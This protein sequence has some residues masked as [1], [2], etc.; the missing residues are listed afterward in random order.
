MKKLKIRYI[1]LFVGT[2][3]LSPP[4]YSFF[5]TSDPGEISGTIKT[6]LVEL[7]SA[8][9]T[10]QSTLNQAK[11]LTAIGDKIGAIKKFVD[12]EALKAKAEE[13]KQLAEENKERLEKLRKKVEEEKSEKETE[14]TEKE[15]EDVATFENFGVDDSLTDE[16]G[17]SSVNIKLPNKEERTFLT[18][19]QNDIPGVSVEKSENLPVV[20]KPSM[21]KLQLPAAKSRGYEKRSSSDE[22]YVVEINVSYAQ[23][24]GVKTGTNN[25]GRFL[26]SDIIATK[27]NM[28]YDEVTKENVD[29]CINTWVQCLDGGSDE[30]SGIEGAL[31]CQGLY[32]KAVHEQV[33]ADLTSALDNKEYANSF[34]ATVA[35]DLENKADTPSSEREDMAYIGLVNKVNQEIL[36]KMLHDESAQL[37]QEALKSIEFVDAAYYKQGD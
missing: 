1:V 33:A 26:Y 27:C 29:K 11:Q 24:S 20:V 5:L 28:N 23:I 25:E 31:S 34:E 4:C 9:N 32:K 37:I 17:D 21:P 6:M 30:E 7:E 15:A 3:L 2:L 22:K 35:K 16:V 12:P 18:D 14:E 13:V 36:I 19:K 8:K 10:V